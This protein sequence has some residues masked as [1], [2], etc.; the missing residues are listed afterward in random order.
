MF[1]RTNSV[2]IGAVS[3]CIWLLMSIEFCTNFNKLKSIFFFNE[4]SKLLDKITITNMILIYIRA[5]RK[6][7]HV[8]F[9]ATVVTDPASRRCAGS[10]ILIKILYHPFPLQTKKEVSSSRFTNYVNTFDKFMDYR[11]PVSYTHL[12]LPTK[13]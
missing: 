9:L 5:W 3:Y 8:S 7:I 1:N 6:K 12:T 10:G 13:A 4:N 11:V 2:L